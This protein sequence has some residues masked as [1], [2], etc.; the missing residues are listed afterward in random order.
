MSQPQICVKFIIRLHLLLRVDAEGPA[1][2]GKGHDG[3]VDREADASKQHNGRVSASREGRWRRSQVSSFNPPVIGQ[4]RDDPA[5]NLDGVSEDT[6]EG[7]LSRG[8]D[9]HLGQLLAPPAHLSSQDI[10][11]NTLL[12]ADHPEAKRSEDARR[13]EEKKFEEPKSVFD[14]PLSPDSP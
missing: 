10:Q 8:R 12:I 1:S 2:G 14:R 9:A 7:E 4:A 11:D 6:G 3:I 5:S 13:S